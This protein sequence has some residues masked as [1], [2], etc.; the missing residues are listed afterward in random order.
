MIFPFVLQL[1]RVLVRWRSQDKCHQLTLNQEVSDQAVDEVSS[2]VNE[3]FLTGVTLNPL[4][5]ICASIS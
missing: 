4:A 2:M 5:F 3:S 1:P